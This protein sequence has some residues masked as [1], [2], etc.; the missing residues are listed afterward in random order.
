MKP[1]SINFNR[2][3]DQHVLYIW[4]LGFRYCFGFRYSYFVF[5]KIPCRRIFVFMQ[6]E[7]NFRKSLML[8]S[9]AIADT[10]NQKTLVNQKKT[11]P[12]EP[13][14]NPIRTQLQNRQKQTPTSVMTGT[15]NEIRLWPQKKTN[16]NEPNSNPIKPNFPRCAF[17]RDLLY[18]RPISI[19]QISTFY[20][21]N[22]A[23]FNHARF[24]FSLTSPQ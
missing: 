19:Y 12:F 7:P 23:S 4:S 9:T 11:N 20:I 2:N 14:T 16:P 10:Y 13:N 6:N 5:P 1:N 17:I 8:L 21:F 18:P 15:Y 24:S 22:F 3:R